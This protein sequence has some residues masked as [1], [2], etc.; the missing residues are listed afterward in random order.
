MNWDCVSELL[1]QHV[2]VI[3]TVKIKAGTQDVHPEFLEVDN[4]LLDHEQNLVYT[5]YLKTLDPITKCTILCSIECGTVTNN[6]LILGHIIDEIKISCNQE[7]IST[8]E[9]EQI[10]KSDTLKRQSNHPYFAQ[11]ISSLTTEELHRRRVDILEWL[12]R[13]RIPA[14]LN[15]DGNEIII[16]DSVKLKPPY[17]SSNDYVCPTR[18][19][20]K[21]IKQIVDNRNTKAE[22]KLIV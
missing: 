4:K 3:S 7:T 18:V 8:S 10:I 14:R 19:V 11:K 5:G 16:A 9:V 2:V 1:Y 13:N 21:R 15:Q 22:R 12:A 20:L 17:D 6:I